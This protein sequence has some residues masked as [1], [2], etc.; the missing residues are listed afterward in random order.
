MA[1]NKLPA[2][3]E[4]LASCSALLELEASHNAI[5]DIPASFSS[6][7]TLQ[8]LRLDSNR[9][10]SVPAELLAGCSALHAL[11]LHDNPITADQLRST[12]G[13]AEYEA[14]RRARCDKQLEAAVLIDL[15]RSFTEGA[16]QQQWQH[17]K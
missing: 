14:R 5:A 8:S 7:T 9:V 3:P 13:F 12:P 6:L 17:W 11:A 15:D 16:D 4:Q 10:P 2:L 1:H